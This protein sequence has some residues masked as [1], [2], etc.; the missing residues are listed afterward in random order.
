MYTIAVAHLLFVTGTPADVEGGSGTFVGISVLRR[1]LEAGGHTVDLL[2]P[3]PG[4][5]ISLA[6]RLLFNL[7]AGSGAPRPRPDVVVGF[8]LD[9]LWLDPGPARSVASI[10]GVL[11]EEARFERGLSRARLKAEAFFE[12]LHVRRVERVLAPSAHSAA[13]IVAR[14]GIPAGRVRIVPEP[15]ELERWKRA[16]ASADEPSRERPSVLCVAHLYPRKDVATLLAAMRRVE[17]ASVLRVV[18][19][20]PELARLRERARRLGIER[21]VEF[22]G[23]ISY[24]RLAAEYRR[25]DVFCL[26]SRQEGFGIVFLEAMAAGLPIVAARAAAVPEIVADQVNGSLVAPGDGPALAREIGRLLEDSTLRRRFGEAGRAR[27]GRYD[28][29]RVAGEFL[30]AIG[31]TEQSPVLRPGSREGI[32]PART[33]KMSS[34]E[35]PERPKAVTVIGRLAMVLAAISFFRSIANL[36]LWSILE[37][38]MPS[39]FN[40]AVTQEPQTWFLQPP[41]RHYTAWETARAVL[42]AAVGV[43]AYFFLRLRPWARLAIQAVCWLVLAYAAAFAVFWARVWGRIFAEAVA[44]RSLSVRSYGTVSF[45]V[46]VAVCMA[47]VAGLAVVISLLRSSRVKAAFASARNAVSNR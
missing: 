3:S 46:G 12:K 18:G 45:L 26:P 19:T 17:D 34:R 13:Q 29:P 10:K 41:F 35:E 23:H 11:A 4:R 21:R 31:L 8:D 33:R 27:V 32:L 37:P 25:A 15:I 42:A 39:L 14:Y 1:A 7:A 5:A 2:A 6:R 24:E 16:L 9:G 20:G 38:A 30:D 36:I 28:A 43:S 44:T 47:V 40:L 22:L